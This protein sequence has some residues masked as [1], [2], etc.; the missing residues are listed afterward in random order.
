MN[1]PVHHTRTS[2]SRARSIGRGLVAGLMTLV[3]LSACSSGS[4]GAPT[5]EDPAATGRE[6]A[7]E[8]LDILQRADTAALEDFLAP[9]FQLQRADGSGYDRNEYLAN[10]AVVNSFELG[11]EV[12]ASQQGDLLVVR[13]ATQA[14]EVTEG[15][16]LSDASAPRLS[17]F[18][19]SDGDWQL[20]SHANFNAPA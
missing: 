12:I 8:F 17:T 16:E 15:T 20:L 6:L 2:H 1:S 3:L 11:D 19:W 10:P 4:S 13:W 5:L 9:A 7:V 14:N 18:V